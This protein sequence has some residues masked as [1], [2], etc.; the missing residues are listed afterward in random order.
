[1]RIDVTRL[2]EGQETVLRATWDPKALDLSFPGRQYK[3]ALDVEATAVR[4]IGIVKVR[5]LLKSDLVLTCSRC[6]KDFESSLDVSFDFI[7]PVDAH[8][9]FIVPDEDIREELILSYPQK[10]LCQEACQGL[11]VRCGA[12]LNEGACKCKS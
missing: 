2:A 12:D 9:R 6:L 8:D 10:V 7:Y 4:D 11:C 3:T 1:M 5:V